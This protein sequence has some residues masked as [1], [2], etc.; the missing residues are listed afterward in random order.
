[1]LKDMQEKL[2][3]LRARKAKADA[4]PEEIKSG[5]QMLYDQICTEITELE[6]DIAEATRTQMVNLMMKTVKDLFDLPWPG[7]DI[8]SQCEKFYP[9]IA[10]RIEAAS[11]SLTEAY[12]SGNEKT[13]NVEVNRYRTAM[14]EMNE[15]VNDPFKQ[16]GLKEIIDEKCPWGK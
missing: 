11:K 1:M 10:R 8:Y 7:N 5:H 15:V 3:E 2:Y 9:E 14:L 13:F 6:R 16:M 4:L 12:N